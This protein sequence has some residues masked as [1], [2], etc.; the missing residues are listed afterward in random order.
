M[1]A[2]SPIPEVALARDAAK[3]ADADMCVVLY[4]NLKKNTLGCASFGTTR[5]LCAK[6]KKLA[7]HCYESAREWW[8]NDL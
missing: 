4:I 5:P 3:K 1:M 8:G 7:D 2:W 6:A